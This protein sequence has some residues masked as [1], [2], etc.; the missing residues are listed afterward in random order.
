MKD[1]KKGLDN[2]MVGLLP[3]LLFL[4]LDNYFSYLLSFAIGVGFFLLC[5]GLYWALSKDR[6]YQFMLLPAAATFVL[7][8]GFICLRLDP[9]L[10]RYSPLVTEVLLV[11]VLTLTG[12][13]KRNVQK[14][15]RDSR[16]PAYQ[17]TLLRTTLNEFYFVAQL[18]QNCYT[19]H[20]F[21]ILLYSIMPAEVKNAY[22]ERFLYRE[23]GVL[24]GFFLLIYEQIRLSLMRGSLSRE[25]WLPALNEEGR[26]VGCIARSVSRSLPKK[27]Y[28]PI[29]RIAVVYGDMLYLGRRGREAFVYPDLL[30][31][32]L[33][34]Y[35]LFRHSI[36]SCV[37]EL[38]APLQREEPSLHPRFLLR[39]TFEDERVKH[40]VSL[41][42]V[43]LPHEALLACCR[44]REGKLWT[45]RQIEE[46]LGKGLFSG[47]FETEFPYLQRTVLLAA[48]LNH[49]TVCDPP[50]QSPPAP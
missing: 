29:I 31:Y 12:F 11:F 26:V 8:A 37:N 9:V 38:V 28:H 33:Y 16:Q 48:Q 50:A 14:R 42:V 27:Y 43:Q 22:T 46:N 41:Y 18:V 40:M 25:M 4:F 3:L 45:V 19:L 13:T 5:I 35:V 34:A 21:V 6:I 44:R 20:L 23:F 30:D 2:Q 39:Y 15:I 36:E 49:T 17:R 47:Y 24:L 32:P 1:I 10:F 7:Y